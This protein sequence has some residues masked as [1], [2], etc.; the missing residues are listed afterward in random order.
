M[1][2]ASRMALLFTDFAT[3]QA[4]RSCV[5]SSGVGSRFVGT[6]KVAGSSVTESLC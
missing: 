3:R 6:V 2:F 5:I 1:C 4:K